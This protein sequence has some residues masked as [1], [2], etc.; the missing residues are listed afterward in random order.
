MSE[1]KQNSHGRQKPEKKSNQE[2]GN[3]RFVV[4]QLLAYRIHGVFWIILH[5]L[6]LPLDVSL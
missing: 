4:F 2:V 3:L 5:F 1:Y 6:R